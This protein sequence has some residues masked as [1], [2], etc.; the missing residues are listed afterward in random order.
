MYPYSINDSNSIAGHHILVVEDSIVLGEVLRFNL[1]QE[2][3]QVT[4]AAD[5]KEAIELFA[6]G[7]YDLV[8]TDYEMPILNG[9]QVCDQLRNECLSDVPIIMCTAKGM[10]LDLHRLA[11][12]YGVKALLQKP[13][14]V[15]ELADLIRGLFAVRA[16]V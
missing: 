16:A 12:K 4:W 9:E 5:G 13:F 15:S 10:E 8:V 1:E 11:D 3:F 7:G 6:Q 14:S 2:G